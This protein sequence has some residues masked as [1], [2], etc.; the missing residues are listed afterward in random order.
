MNTNIKNTLSVIAFLDILGGKEL[1]NKNADESLNLVYTSYTEAI[2]KF[3]EK[4]NPHLPIPHINIW[5][6]LW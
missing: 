1:I 5:W 6:K 2:T 4:A 3:K